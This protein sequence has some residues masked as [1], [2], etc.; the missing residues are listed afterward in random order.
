MDKLDLY[1]AKN[2]I[3]EPPDDFPAMVRLHFRCRQRKFRM[4]RAGLSFSLVCL[5]IIFVIPGIANLNGHILLPSSGL[6]ILEYLSKELL[7]LEGLLGQ[8]WQGMNGLSYTMQNSLGL[9]SSLGLIAIGLGS[10]IGIESF[11][12]RLK[13]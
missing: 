9:T 11:F 6:P 10:L 7:N 2:P 5:G 4:I 8:S 12:P 3:E 13:V 1:L